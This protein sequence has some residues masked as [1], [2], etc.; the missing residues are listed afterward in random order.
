MWMGMYFVWW[1]R[2]MGEAGLGLDTPR[3]AWLLDHR[4]Y[5]RYAALLDHRSYRRYARQFDRRS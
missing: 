2:F 3:Y 1:R 5:K 4:S